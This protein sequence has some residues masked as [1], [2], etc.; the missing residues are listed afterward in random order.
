MK[1]KFKL[2]YHII[3][4]PVCSSLQSLGEIM[5]LHLKLTNVKMSFYK[6]LVI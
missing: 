6:Q 5:T 3:H 1:Y 4:L 2:K